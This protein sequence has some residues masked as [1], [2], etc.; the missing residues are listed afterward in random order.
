MRKLPGSLLLPAFLVVYA[1]FFIGS[2]DG[3]LAGDDHFALAHAAALLAGDRLNVDLF[4]P[5]VPLQVVVS[6][7][8]QLASGS[9]TIAEVL[10]ALSLRIIG[11]VSV[12]M[13]TKKLVHNRLAGVLV[14]ATVAVGLMNETI[15]GPEK[16]ALYPIAVLAVWRYLEGRLSPYVL[17]LI[18]A[19]AALLRH[20]HGVYVAICMALAVSLGPRPVAS[21]LKVGG[22]TLVLMA[23]WLLWV[24]STEGIASYVTSRIVFA[25]S[26]GLGSERPFGFRTPLLSTAN[27]ARW[28]WHVAL[29]TTVVALIMSI[30]RR[31][32]P[33]IALAGTSVV[34][35]L[36]LMRKDAQAVEVA[37]I[38][39]PL[40]VWLI[41]NVRWY[42]KVALTCV[43]AVSIAAVITMNDA[44]SEL[45][46][47]AQEGGGLRRRLRSAVQF[48]MTTPPIDAYAPVD[49][50]ETSEGRTVIRY[51]YECLRPSDRV[52]ETAMWFPVTYYSQR[53]PVW[54]LYWDHS[55]KQDEASQLQFLDWL[56]GE[57]A[58]VIIAH[59][60]DLL[61]AFRRYPLIRSYVTA[62]YREITSARF[63]EYRKD[64]NRI[65][66]LA[67]MRRVPTGRF[68]PL[69]LPCFS[70]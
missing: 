54:H 10:I 25:M 33:V 44:V 56:K 31:S 63:E 16:V 45:T 11:L 17:S 57:Q 1:A 20:D 8:G 64:G 21:L 58:P 36:G 62:N 40:L 49:P 39:M 22:G 52:W 37:A 13:L 65:R 30:R 19:T 47:I 66:L 53:R 29:L 35:A 32:I 7:V 67:D 14:A 3:R 70:P 23:P 34:T 6:A 18:I 12:Y 26:I 60:D 9:R 28:L 68:E 4:D 24:Q 38:W 51:V 69:D 5:G 41:W 55:L 59:S 48:H 61:V 27:A 42:G 43:A 2:V 46:Q 50:E 15:Y